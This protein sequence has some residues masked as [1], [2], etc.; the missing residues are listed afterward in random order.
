MSVAELWAF[1]DRRQADAEPYWDAAHGGYNQVDGTE[2]V[3][4]DANMLQVHATAALAGHAGATRRD[5]RVIALVDLLTRG[6]AFIAPPIAAPT[7]THG[8]SPGWTSSTRRPGRQHVA[9][10]AQVV[11]ALVAAW[12]ARDVVGLSATLR[13]RIAGSISAVAASPFF[14]YPSQFLTQWNWHADLDAAAYRVTGD[15]TFLDD[16][17]RQLSRF[18]R[19]SRIAL[20]PAR[21]PFLNPGLGLLYAQR[22]ADAIG[23]PLLSTA[24]YENLVLS[25]LR[26]YDMAVQAGMRPL[27]TAQEKR[28]R[29][30]SRRVMLGDWTHAGTL[31]W[32]TSLGTRRW[33]LARYWAF[34]QQGLE[35][36]ISA[37]RLSAVGGQ[38]A[39][40]ASVAD[41]GLRTYERWAA[42]YPDGRLPSQL[43]GVAGRD[44]SESN[45]PVFTA[46]RVQAHAT[47]VAQLR[48]GAPAPERPPAWFARDNGA[49]RLAVSTPAYST[50]VLVRHP[51]DDYGGVELARLLN[52]DGMPVSGLGGKG[53]SAF[54]LDLV[55]R[56]ETL[57]DTQPGRSTV[58]R[59]RTSVRVDAGKGRSNVRD[60][61]TGALRVRSS[62]RNSAGSVAVHQRFHRAFIVVR[63]SV[64]AR[65]TATATVRFPAWGEGAVLSVVRRSGRREPLTERSVS[66]VGAVGLVVSSA[67]GGYAVDLCSIPRGARLRLATVDPVPTSPHTVRVALLSMRVPDGAKRTTTVRITP[68]T[69]EPPSPNGAPGACR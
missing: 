31:N 1:A 10:D 34:A 42:L 6:P 38:P 40:A 39:W 28:L 35:T 67:S 5:D 54:G 11:E 44:R 56:G 3:R 45:D 27:S 16:Y 55:R 37:G 26:H 63:R 25:G 21:T 59:G 50:G 23:A 64:E 36:L 14:R 20:D 30:W 58:R 19:G 29:D 13:E 12:D 17:R 24:E 4:L 46:T 7:G 68:T 15:R 33:W 60:T 18:V 9:I 32:D 49:G 69:G 48:A 51:T 61:F 62:V 2:D 57:L 41:A 47:R 65:R 53:R 66:A 8:H 43:W 52:A 22:K